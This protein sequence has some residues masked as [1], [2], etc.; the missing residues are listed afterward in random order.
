MNDVIVV[1]EF[2]GIL[3]EAFIKN[4]INAIS[5]DILPSELPGPHIQ[6]DNDLHLKD[7]LYSNNWK[8]V[9]AFPP[10]TRLTNSVIWYI[11]KNNLWDDVY[12]SAVFFNMILNSPAKYKLLENPIQHP[13]VRKKNEFNSELI[14]K[15]DQIIQPF[16]FGHDAKKATC[17]WLENLPFLK[18]TNIILKNRYSNQTPTG[19][20][21][22]LPGPNRW[23]ER[24]RTFTGI[25]AAIASQYKTILQ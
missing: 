2:S 6:V 12:Q 17:L 9:F 10:C 16:Q 18:P 5:A 15:Y 4:G 20:N 19:Q 22:E 23:K 14:R 21:K 25:A 13:Y 24:S 1:C 3:R 8:A 11:K 7:V